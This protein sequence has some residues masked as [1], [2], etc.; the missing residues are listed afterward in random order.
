M[1]FEVNFKNKRNISCHIDD[2]L[3]STTHIEVP[4]EEIISMLH[5]I[6]DDWD[7]VRLRD[8]MELSHAAGRIIS[9]FEEGKE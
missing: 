1:K 6:A 7:L 3:V 5:D 8:R 4:V 2:N 9:Y